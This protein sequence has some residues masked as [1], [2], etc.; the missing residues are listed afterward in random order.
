MA[1]KK[2]ARKGD[3]NLS[4]FKNNE[5]DVIKV[6]D[7]HKDMVIRKEDIVKIMANWEQNTKILL[8]YQIH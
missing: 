6:I 5:E 1:C 4:L 8:K 7:E 3:N 2:L